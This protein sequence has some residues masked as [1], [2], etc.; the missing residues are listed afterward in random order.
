MDLTAELSTFYEALLPVAA[1]YGLD[2]ADI[3]WRL[4]ESQRMYELAAYAL[5]GR[6]PHWT[7][8]RDYWTLKQQYTRGHG[9]LYEIVFGGRPA[10]AYLL[11]GNTVAAQK[12]VMAH[13]LGHVD[14]DRSHLYLREV[15]DDLMGSFQRAQFRAQAYQEEYGIEAVEILLDRALSIQMQGAEEP[16]RHEEKPTV[17]DNPYADLFAPQKRLKP[18]TRPRYAL[19]TTD[20]LGFIARESP[21]LDDWERDLCQVV[22]QEGLYFQRLRAVKSLHE[23]YA[24]YMNQ[25]VLLDPRVPMT[26]GE[27]TESAILF[28]HVA[29]PDPRDLNPYWFG[30]R[31]LEWLVQECGWAEAQAIWRTETDASLI[32][33]YC[34][35]D[36][37]RFL[38]LYV[39]DWAQEWVPNGGQAWVA[40]RQMADWEEIRD[41]LANA[42]GRQDPIIRVVSVTPAG[43]LE[44]QHD[45]DG[46]TLDRQWAEKT[47]RAIADLWGNSV[48]LVDGTEAP[49]IVSS[50]AK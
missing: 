19:P 20:L 1:E 47:C 18:L 5:P 40:R 11:E 2:V 32:R 39:Y 38:N 28:A 23:G 48:R 16:P 41:G 10:T 49:L 14:L 25:H 27:Q 50:H 15:R 13:V 29:S 33:N 6:M 24:A 34:T 45:A 21:V 46:Q 12:L 37:I 35:Q 26:L 7:H 30:W 9:R 42:L 43:I 44:L 36:T 8:G 3:D 22:R 17:P 31:F 4:V